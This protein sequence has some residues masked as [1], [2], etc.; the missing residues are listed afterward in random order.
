MFRNS[1][2]R[3]HRLQDTIARSRDRQLFSREER[4]IIMLPM[5]SHVRRGRGARHI[6]FI[7]SPL[8]HGIVNASGIVQR[9]EKLDRFSAVVPSSRRK[10]GIILI[11]YR[12]SPCI[13]VLSTPLHCQ[14]VPLDIG[15]IA[16]HDRSQVIP[17]SFSVR[18][19]PPPSRKLNPE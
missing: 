13:A 1:S 18:R 15:C 10:T 4:F 11:T 2:P 6:K 19:R 7:T 3:L 17:A 9:R 5:A 14:T 8:A 16:C 12:H